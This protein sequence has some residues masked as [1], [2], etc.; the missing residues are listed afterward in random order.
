MSNKWGPPDHQREKRSL[1]FGRM[2]RLRN[3]N[4]R[5]KRIDIFI[6]AIHIVAIGQNTYKAK[7]GAQTGGI[8]GSDQSQPTR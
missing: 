6:R 1:L 7:G 5:L 8:H 2:F 4:H 3:G